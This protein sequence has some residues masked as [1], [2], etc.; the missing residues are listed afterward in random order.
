MSFDLGFSLALLGKYMP[1]VN[2]CCAPVVRGEMRY[3][4][5][6][7]E[8]RE[9]IHMSQGIWLRERQCYETI[10]RQVVGDVV[11]GPPNL[12]KLLP[13]VTVAVCAADCQSIIWMG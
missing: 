6:K 7:D 8:P 13:I 3:I 1:N 2:P 4:Q 12:R 11:A 10:T 9:G 5:C